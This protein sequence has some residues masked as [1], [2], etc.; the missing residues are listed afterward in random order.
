[1]ANSFAANG[2][3]EWTYHLQDIYNFEKQKLRQFTKYNLQYISI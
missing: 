2:M 1:M 3:N